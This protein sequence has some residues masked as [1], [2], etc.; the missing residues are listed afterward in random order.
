MCDMLGDT[1]VYVALA[2]RP[3]APQNLTLARDGSSVRLRWQPPRVAREVAG[4]NVY[5]SQQS[6]RGTARQPGAN[7]LTE[8]VDTPPSGPAFYRRSRREH[9]GLEGCTRRK[10]CRGSSELRIY[11]DV[12][13]GSRRRLCASIRRGLLQ[14]PLRA[15]V[16]GNVA[17]S[18]RPGDVEDK[19]PGTRSY[20]VWLRGK[21]KEFPVQHPGTS[22]TARSTPTTGPGCARSTALRLLGE[23]SRWFP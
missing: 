15:S 14:L 7:L 9:C 23:R 8:F 2:R 17:G 16:E 22:V 5:R 12:E 4:Y 21:G 3:E 10:S 1:D 13:E 20:D 11:A 6:G 19:H 18:H